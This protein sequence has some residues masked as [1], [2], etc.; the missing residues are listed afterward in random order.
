MKKVGLLLA[1]VMVL[2]LFTACAA[3]AE[4]SQAPAES[5]A[6]VESSAAPA[7]GAIGTIGVVFD[8]L[9][10]ERRVLAKNYLEQYAKEANVDL[11]FMDANGD[12]KVQMEQAENLITKDVDVLVV[13]AQNADTAA[14]MVKQAKEA[15]I[16]FVTTDRMI[17]NAD[18]D[19][20]VGINNDVIGDMMAQYAYDKCPKGNYI[21]ISGAPTDPNCKVYKDGWMRV[22]GDA[23]DKGDIK[24]VGD[25]DTENWDPN[26]AFKNVENFLT[27]NDDNVDVI[28]AMND[29]TGGG[30]VQALK[31]REL[32]GKVLVTGQDGELAACQRIVTGDQAMTVWKPDNE[33]SRLTIDTCV[34]IIK[35]EKPAVTATINN[36]FKDVECV[37]VDPVT[38]H[39]DNMDDTIIAAG[40]YTREDVYATAE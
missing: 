28:L 22:I 23:V 12:E 5:S 38:V 1:V 13:L 3:P 39:K 33:V 8:F 17:A 35:G 4:S 25:A 19:Y 16:P 26:N 15:G 30:S 27:A 29:G 21:L 14:P 40:Y 24:I 32:N 7:E 11:I 9:Q 36:G 37:L 6:P 18:V 34:K 10:V 31:A 2:S 20:F